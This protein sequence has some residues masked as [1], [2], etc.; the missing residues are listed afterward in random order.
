MAIRDY[1]NCTLTVEVILR[2]FQRFKGIVLRESNSNC[3]STIS[4]QIAIINIQTIKKFILGQENRDVFCA[5]DTKM[6]PELTG[7]KN[8]NVKMFQILISNELLQNE[9]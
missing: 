9:L 8:T 6:V 5:L 2:N 4:L 7:F 1:L 3:F